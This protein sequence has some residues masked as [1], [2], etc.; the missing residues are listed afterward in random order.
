MT[1]IDVR[2]SRELQAVI[3]AMKKAGKELRTSIYSESRRI[4][5]QEWTFALYERARTAFEHRVLV[6]GARIRVGTQGFTVT[7]AKSRK[8]LRGGLKPVEDWHAA[9]FGANPRK[10]T[11][12]T[13]S[14]KGKAYTVT[15]IINRQLRRRNRQ[16]YVVMPAARNIGTRL[17][18]LWVQ[19]VVREFR[20]AFDRKG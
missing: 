11:V 1:K 3:F 5:G 16:G 14:R 19:I 6:Q 10:A 20:N 4:L 15:K 18:A 2:G 13:T 9:E 17:V 7:T 8:P 12:E